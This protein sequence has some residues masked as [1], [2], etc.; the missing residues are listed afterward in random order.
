[1]KAKH[2]K[3]QE[4]KANTGRLVYNQCSNKMKVKLDRTSGYEQSKKD[5]DLIALP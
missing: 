5:N 1:M 3:Y 2:K 4:N